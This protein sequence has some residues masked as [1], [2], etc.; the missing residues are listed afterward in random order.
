[1]SLLTGDVIVHIE[2][3]KSTTAKIGELKESLARSV[4]IKSIVFLYSCKK[5]LENKT[6]KMISFKTVS[7]YHIPRNKSNE[8]STGFKKTHNILLRE[9]NEDLN[10]CRYKSSSR[11]RRCN[12]VNM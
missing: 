2:N 4:N 12:I 11:S 3:P 5:Q 7:K 6:I 9:I 8:R 1:M 10:K